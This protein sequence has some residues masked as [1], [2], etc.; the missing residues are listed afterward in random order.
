MRLPIEYLRQ[1]KLRRIAQNSSKSKH[2]Q[3]RD[4][5]S[6]PPFHHPR[7]KYIPCLHSH[8]HLHHSIN[9]KI[10]YPKKLENHS[11][12]QFHPPKCHCM[13]KSLIQP[14]HI[15]NSHNFSVYNGARNRPTVHTSMRIK[16]L[17]THML[18]I[19]TQ[20]KTNRV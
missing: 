5:R 6:R 20:T 10:I 17:R 14:T 2:K 3:R 19:K 1:W 9:L 12:F 15:G 18:Y 7:P 11:K 4:R 16:Q 8:K 13:P